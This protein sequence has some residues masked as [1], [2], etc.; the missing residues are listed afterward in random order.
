MPPADDAYDDHHGFWRPS[1]I[2]AGIIL[3]LILLVAGLVIAIKVSGGHRHADTT[4]SPSPTVSSAP[5]S[6]SPGTA[7]TSSTGQTCNLPAGSQTVPDATPLGITWKIY[8]TVALPFSS[9][10]GPE[11]VD[12]GVARCYAHN[13]TGALIA[14]SQ[15]PYRYLIAPDWR[16][17]VNQQVVDNSGRSVYITNRA[18]ASNQG[19]NQP[20]DYNQ[21]AGFK[22]V[23]YSQ[24]QA[25]IEFVSQ[26]AQGVMQA[27]TTTVDWVGGDWQLDLQPDGG[28]SPN[29]LPVTSINGFS[30]WA[31]V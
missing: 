25:V 16:Q 31:G 2:A 28:P 17:V 14:A 30:Q 5:G 22:F 15:I 21:L 18:A 19:G 6:T 10:Y 26:S 3:L 8:Q 29:A 9:K 12:G 4:P 11:Y 23:D 24:S 13:P 7:R 20:G 27:T 1:T